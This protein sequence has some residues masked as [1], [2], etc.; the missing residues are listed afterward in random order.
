MVPLCAR[1]SAHSQSEMGMNHAEFYITNGRAAEEYF[2]ITTSSLYAC[3]TVHGS[4]PND[5]NITHVE[6]LS[7]IHI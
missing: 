3:K 1:A 6:L 2:V 5:L 7:L 4:D